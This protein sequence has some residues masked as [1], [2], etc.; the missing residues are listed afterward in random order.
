MPD[1]IGLCQKISYMLTNKRS[2]RHILG[3]NGLNYI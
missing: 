1:E 2:E 3:T